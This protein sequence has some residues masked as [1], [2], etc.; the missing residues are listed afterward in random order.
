MANLRTLSDKHRR[1]ARLKHA[2]S[3][4]VRIAEECGA[5]ASTVKMWMHSPL[6]QAYIKELDEKAVEEH[7]MRDSGAAVTK[8]LTIIERQ[9]PTAARKLKDM[10]EPEYFN[11]LDH[12]ERMELIE[13]I[14]TFAGIGPDKGVKS[15]P[16][17]QVIINQSQLDNAAKTRKM[18]TDA[19]RIEINEDGSPKRDGG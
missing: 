18:L 1:A 4:N 13:K 7:I 16:N 8:A 14:L 3:S 12:K 15:G 9:A 5:H 19:D 11:S 2:G 10:L 6:F 17:V